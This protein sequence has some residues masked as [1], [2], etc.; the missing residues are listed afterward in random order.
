MGFQNSA[1]KFAFLTSSFHAD[2]NDLG[3]HVENH[4]DTVMRTAE[5]PNHMYDSKKPDVENKEQ[6]FDLRA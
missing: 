2:T 5:L 4:C 6:G 1:Q 3:A